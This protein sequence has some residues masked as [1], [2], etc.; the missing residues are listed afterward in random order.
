MSCDCGSFTKNLKSV[1]GQGYE[2][3]Q[4]ALKLLSEDLRLWDI[5]QLDCI[6][7][8]GKEI[9]PTKVVKIYKNNE[10][11]SNVAVSKESEMDNNGG[12]DNDYEDV[13]GY[14][15]VGY[16]IRNASLSRVGSGEWYA[17]QQ[18]DADGRGA[19]G[20]SEK[21]E[22]QDRVVSVG[23]G[24]KVPPGATRVNISGRAVSSS[25]SKTSGSVANSP[26]SGNRRGVQS[27]SSIGASSAKES[28]VSNSKYGSMKRVSIADSLNSSDVQSAS[29]N[30]KYDSSSFTDSNG[31]VNLSG[32]ED[33]NSP[34]YTDV[35]EGSSSASAV[36]MKILKGVTP[37]TRR[38]QVLPPLVKTSKSIGSNSAKLTQPSR[39]KQ[40]KNQSSGKNSGI[41]IDTSPGSS[42]I[43]TAISP[44]GG[45]ATLLPSID[46]TALLSPRRSP[47]LSPRGTGL[48]FNH[49][50]TTRA[51]VVSAR[52][53]SLSDEVDSDPLQQVCSN[54]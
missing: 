5:E 15:D 12:R 7:N 47:K 51:I 26:G 33:I 14:D 2:L 37:S 30:S 36:A 4:N 18:T 53:T 23:G 22:L 21:S 10:R 38:V 8:L 20:A 28:P 48:D 50:S 54:V 27:R 39:S 11:Y 31:H 17:S 49:A 3:I 41:Q 46:A 19:M 29:V 43:N 35:N 13:S 44:Q 1:S 45:G 16:D 24:T 32:M 40:S 25:S 52:G 42:G 6:K 34:S 9:V